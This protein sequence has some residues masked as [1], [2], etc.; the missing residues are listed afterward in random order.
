MN[1]FP[2][3]KSDPNGITKDSNFQTFL[4]SFFTLF[5]SSGGEDWEY[6]LAS[7]S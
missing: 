3:V 5:K 1:L 4:T 6:I 2:Y 7:T